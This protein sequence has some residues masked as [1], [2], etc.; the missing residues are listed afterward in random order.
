[1]CVMMMLL[2]ITP[3][4]ADVCHSSYEG[5]IQKS[6]PNPERERIGDVAGGT[7][8][9]VAV[10]RNETCRSN[11]NEKETVRRGGRRLQATSDIRWEYF[12]SEVSVVTTI[13]TYV[14]GA[15][16]TSCTTS[17]NVVESKPNPTHFKHVIQPGGTF[18]SVICTADFPGRP[19]F[20][21]WY[22]GGT[23]NSVEVHLLTG[24][25]SKLPR[26]SVN[27]GVGAVARIYEAVTPWRAYV[28]Q[29]FV[30]LSSTRQNT[31]RAYMDQEYYQPGEE[32]DSAR[33][34]ADQ[35]VSRKMTKPGM[36]RPGE[37]PQ[38]Y[39]S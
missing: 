1:M 12:G 37:R 19:Y 13:E 14:S 32:T 4:V 28:K 7:L 25:G 23:S 9:S 29:N 36:T 15:S 27:G 35:V 31:L 5:D 24:T 17:G 38:R 16:S 6:V 3:T 18:W 33:S 2:Y 34:W 39:K 20:S 30:A 22:T 8:K 21:G 11:R 10:G 26:I